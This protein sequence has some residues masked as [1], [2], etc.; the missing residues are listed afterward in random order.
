[1]VPGLNHRAAH[2]IALSALLAALA[3][4]APRLAVMTAFALSVVWVAGRDNDAGTWG[5]SYAVFLLILAV[6]TVLI[7]ALALIHRAASG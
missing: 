2:R 5:V 7:F 6:L 3:I 4:V 1:M